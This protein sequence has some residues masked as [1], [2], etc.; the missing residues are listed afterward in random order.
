[1]ARTTLCNFRIL[2]NHTLSWAQACHDVEKPWALP[3]WLVYATVSILV[4]LCSGLMF[5]PKTNFVIAD[6][7]RWM[8]IHM[9]AEAFFEVFTTVLIG[10]F[11]VLMGLVSERAATRVIYLACLLF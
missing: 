4:L 2:G 3:N 1:M 8:V 6:F 9:W 7:W 5:T 11:M 10:Y